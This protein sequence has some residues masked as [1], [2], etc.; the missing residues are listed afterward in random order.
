MAREGK[1]RTQP[2]TSLAL[3]LL[4]TLDVLLIFLWKGVAVKET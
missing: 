2:G 3:G 1:R 4:D